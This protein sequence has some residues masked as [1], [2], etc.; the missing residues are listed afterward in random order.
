MPGLRNPGAPWAPASGRKPSARHCHLQVDSSLLSGTL[1]KGDSFLSNASLVNPFWIPQGRTYVHT[2]PPYAGPHLL[3][4]PAWG[5]STQ[6]LSPAKG[7]I[8]H[9]LLFLPFLG[10][11]G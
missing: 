8:L 2:P 11:R 5:L 10:G 7:M 1:V 3:R 6:V 4:G 9:K